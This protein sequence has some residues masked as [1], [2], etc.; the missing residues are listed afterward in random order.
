M[1]KKTPA[2]P[3]PTADPKRFIVKIAK[4]LSAHP[5]EQTLLLTP[6][7]MLELR[8]DV[9]RNPLTRFLFVRTFKPKMQYNGRPVCS[10]ELIAD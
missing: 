2:G 9:K 8:T 7:T 4:R 1:E 3:S 10:G 6:G 5:F